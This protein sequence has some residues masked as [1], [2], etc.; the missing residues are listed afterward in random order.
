MINL[1]DKIALVT[2]GTSG[3]GLAI[4]KLYVEL[5]AKVIITG[6]RD[7]GQSIAKSVGAVF[8]QCDV[9]KDEQVAQLACQIKAE[10]GNVN[11]LVNN[12]GIYEPIGLVEDADMD[13][14]DRLTSVDYRSVFLV[15][16]AIK[17]LMAAG[18]SIV[19]TASTAALMGVPADS[20]YCAVKAALIGLTRSLSLELAEVGIRINAISPGAINTD[21][22]PED[23][24]LISA[25]QKLIPLGRLGEATE[26]ANTA[27]FLGS[28]ASS[29]ITGQNLVVDGGFTS[30]HTGATFGGLIG[31]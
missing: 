8:I 21:M 28:S 19:N 11:V 13:V 17:P 16:R 18:D 22:W 24:P 23:E 30:G 14:F 10:Y 26:I 1:Q 9:S 29:Y 2:G 4:A 5:G 6:R 27:A 3:I 15:T 31:E 25:L 7:N 20:A 12:A